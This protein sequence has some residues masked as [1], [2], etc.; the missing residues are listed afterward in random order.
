M[1]LDFTLFRHN[2]Q[3]VLVANHEVTELDWDRYLNKNAYIKDTSHMQFAAASC[4]S[5]F[6]SVLILQA[7]SQRMRG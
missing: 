5:N 7:S 4:N 2:L 1:F 3:E 6:D